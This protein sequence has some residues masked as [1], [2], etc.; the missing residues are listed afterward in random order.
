MLPAGGIRFSF[1]LR[2]ARDGVIAHNLV[3]DAKPVIALAEL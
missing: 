2:A 3:T 1:Y